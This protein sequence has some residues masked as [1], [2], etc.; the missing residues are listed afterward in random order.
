[1]TLKLPIYLDY[2]A[3]T[4]MDPRVIEAM[5]DCM[6]NHFGNPHSRT[7]SFG[8]KA[9][10]LVEIARKKVANLINADEKEIFFTS[11]ATESNNIAIK[12]VA[13]FYGAS[14]KNHIITVATEHKCV[15]NSAR[16]L[17]QE[18][19]IVHRASCIGD[20]TRHEARSTKHETFTTTFLPVQKNGLIDLNQLEMAITD[21]TCLVS[22]MGVNNEIGVIQ[23]LAEIGKI[24]RKKGVFFHSDC[25]QAFGKIPLDVEAMNIDLMSISGHKIYGPKGIGAIYVRRK[26]RVRIK[27]VFSGGGQE[28]G[29]RSGTVPTPLVVGF[30]V[31]AEIAKNE[32]Q[33]DHEHIKK[34]S[35]KFYQAVMKLTH[36]YLNGDYEK[37]IPGN[38][39]FSFAGIEGES[40]IMAIKDLA[41][42]SGS[43]CT[44]SSLEPSYVLHSLGVEDELAHTSIRFGLGRFTTEE[45][46]DYAIKLIGEKVNKLRELSP[47]WEM[48]QDGIDI[49]SINWKS[50]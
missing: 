4:P 20:S 43:A 34:L 22:A 31:A 17:E 39:N 6:K 11:G 12:G 19:C 32:M 38:L 5:V 28:R 47:L 3:T 35:N 46:I 44:S 25:A 36:V 33:K 37:R 29:I 7:H 45:E 9:E 14:G 18:S 41:V 50:H 27:P 1:M 15:I 10:E 21:K 40:M 13:R 23:P 26:P 16:D 30:G 48:M 42:S 49:K 8:W 24:C 2:Q